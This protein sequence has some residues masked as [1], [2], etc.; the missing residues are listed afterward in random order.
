MPTKLERI[1]PEDVGISPAILLKYLESLEQTGFIA[2]HI[3]I[4][5]HGKVAFEVHFNPFRPDI[6]HMLCSC[7]KSVT[8]AA[9]G[10][11]ID[12]GLISID[13]RIVDIF[14]E[15][16]DGQP[17]PFIQAITVRHLLMMSTVYD[18]ERIKITSDDWTRDF[19][20][21]EPLHY[22]GT[23][24][25]YDSTGT[26]VLCEIVQKLAKMTVH[27]YLTPRL[28][29]P[30]GIG[31]DEVSWELN[32]MGINH[33][34]GG[35]CLTPEAMAKFGL[36]HLNGGK[37][38]GKQ[39][40]PKDWAKEIATPRVSCVSC[41]GTF[42][43]QYGYKFWRVQDNGFACLGLAGQAIVMHPDKDIVFVGA[44]NGFQTDYHY[45]HMNYFWL[46]VYPH[47]ADGPI[48]YE[49]KAYER[50]QEYVKNAEVFLPG[51]ST[52][53]HKNDYDTCFM[54]VEKNKLGC[55]GFT[56]EFCE[57]YGN[58]ILK[59]KAREIIIPFGYGKHIPGPLGLQSFAKQTGDDYPNECAAAGNWVDS[60][61]FIIQSHVI[62]TL[63]Y[64]LITCHFGEKA[65]VL[66]IKPYGVYSY[67][68][69]PISLT[70][71]R[72]ST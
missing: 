67:D 28:F 23:I 24:F 27:E 1:R 33:G 38:E 13:D 18:D 4:I 59:L 26:H 43:G 17:H 66:E 64:F 45:F 41:D 47:I 15:K 2:H 6:R 65:T 19:L 20:N 68:V 54:P 48:P 34:G 53:M 8:A 37:W 72:R 3:M 60:R 51:A 57:G 55:E 7:S 9:I 56:I 71:M 21:G 40:L 29:E 52:Y 30:L 70:S 62:D 61:T 5:R 22:P 50:L 36:L 58:L 35:A 44:A 10:F 31:K 39:V 16:L 25:S 69:F 42:K 49:E 12:E 46:L 14:P 63:Q 11:A 32:P